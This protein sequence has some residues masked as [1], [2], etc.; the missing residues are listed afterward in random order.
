MA[1]HAGPYGEAPG[2]VRRPWPLLEFCGK[3]RQG[4]ANRLGL[5][6]LNDFYRLYVIRVVSGCLVLVPRMVKAG[7]WCH[8]WLWIGLFLHIKGMLPAGPYAV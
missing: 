7:K 4:R 6:N 5:A 1:P 8:L 3:T 2:L